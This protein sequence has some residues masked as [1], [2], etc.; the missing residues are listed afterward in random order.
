MLRQNICAPRAPSNISL[1]ACSEK[2]MRSAYLR[3]ER[4]PHSSYS[5][6]YF[7]LACSEKCLHSACAQNIK[8]TPRALTQKEFG[9]VD[10][11]APTGPAIES[12]RT[13]NNVSH[14]PERVVGPPG[15]T[16]YNRSVSI[17]NY[18]ADSRSTSLGA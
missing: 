4:V 6:R 13:S 11:T 10:Y 14:D 8:R 9:F 12:T 2:Y 3:T 16:W 15:S 7:A 5:Q 17:F 1:L 18:F